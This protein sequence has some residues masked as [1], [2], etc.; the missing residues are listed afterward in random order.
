MQSHLKDNETISSVTKESDDSAKEKTVES[1]DITTE[2]EN[3][4]D[5]FGTQEFKDQSF[6]FMILPSKSLNPHLC[7]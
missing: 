2:N 4:S 1:C 3:S 5:L 6:G 7:N